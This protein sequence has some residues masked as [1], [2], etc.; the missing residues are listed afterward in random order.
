MILDLPQPCFQWIIA[1]KKIFNFQRNLLNIAL[2]FDI[3]NILYVKY[4]YFT[5]KVWNGFT[6]IKIFGHLLKKLKKN[7]LS[8]KLGNKYILI[9]V[10]TF[11]QYYNQGISY[12]IRHEFNVTYSTNLWWNDNFH[13]S[14]KSQLTNK[15]KSIINNWNCNTLY[16]PNVVHKSCMHYRFSLQHKRNVLFELD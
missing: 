9:D 15:S 5:A 13:G 7:P 11:A 4:M 3:I 16:D 8:L 2:L 10:R 6:D 12:F 14:F 1:D